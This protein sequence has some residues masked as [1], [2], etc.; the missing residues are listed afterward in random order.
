M[1]AF[2]V[3]PLN[4]ALFLKFY[5]FHLWKKKLK[6]CGR[7]SLRRKMQG[8]YHVAQHATKGGNCRGTVLEGLHKKSSNP[9]PS[10]GHSQ[11]Y[12]HLPKQKFIKFPTESTDMLYHFT[13]L[14]KGN[15]QN[16]L[17]NL[18]FSRQMDCLKLG[19]LTTAFLLTRHMVH[20][21][22]LLFLLFG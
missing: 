16:H 12:S 8:K 21:Y 13:L 3:L 2:S 14:N 7:F 1:S 4:W 17:F 20:S 22:Q 15:K 6:M 5:I 18:L 9:P 19:T 11:E 10:S